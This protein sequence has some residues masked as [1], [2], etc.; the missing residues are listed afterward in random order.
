MDSNTTAISTDWVPLRR[1]AQM[2]RDEHG[3]EQV[4]LFGSRARGDERKNSD[5]D[6]IVVSPYFAQVPIVDR[7][8]ELYA[9]W[10]RARGYGPINLICLTPDE[11]ETARRRITLVAEV[12]PEAVDLL[13]DAAYT[14]GT[15]PAYHA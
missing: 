13:A 10:K 6:F 11:L 1:F 15:H 5:Y 4:W 8:R 7:G 9:L 2:V 12:L 3:A 14:E